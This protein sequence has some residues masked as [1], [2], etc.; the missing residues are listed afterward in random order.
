MREFNAIAYWKSLN[1]ADFDRYTPL[2]GT[3]PTDRQIREIA[4]FISHLPHNQKML[5][6]FWRFVFRMDIKTIKRY[7]GI[8]YANGVI[9]VLRFSCKRCLN[10]DKNISD[11]GMAK[12]F[13]QL[14]PDFEI[15]LV[16]SQAGICWHRKTLIDPYILQNAIDFYKQRE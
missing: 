9:E 1:P 8:D 13:E 3:M 11:N 14:L 10:I 5:L 4:A 6:Y 16:S 2:K 7:S 15:L 12:A